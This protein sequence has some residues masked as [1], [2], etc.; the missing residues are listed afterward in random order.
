[1]PKTREFWREVDVSLWRKDEL[2]AACTLLGLPTSGKKM[3]LITRIQDWVH[4]PEILARL[5]HQR[6]L[7]LQHE[8]ILASG[9]VFAFGSNSNGE[10][11][12][13]HR[14]AC[15]IPTELESFRGAHVTNVYSVR[16]QSAYVMRFLSSCFD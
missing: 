13:G 12:L 11:G 5:Q 10:L 9:R 7:E 1:M 8:A 15:E 2:D 4:E 16:G 3:E 14:R 6:S